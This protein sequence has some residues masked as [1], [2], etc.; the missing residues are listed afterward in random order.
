MSSMSFRYII[1]GTSPSI[2]PHSHNDIDGCQIDMNGAGV[3]RS[4]LGER[5]WRVRSA[6]SSHM[7]LGKWTAWVVAKAGNGRQNEICLIIPGS[8]LKFPGY[9]SL[10]VPSPLLPPDSL[11][12]SF[13]RGLIKP[14]S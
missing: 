12:L 11:T 5:H 7:L 2:S 8:E 6:V 3:W 9:S 4:S 14:N 13:Q 1:E 10:R